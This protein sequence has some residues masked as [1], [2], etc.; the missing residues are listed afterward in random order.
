MD[1]DPVALAL[2]PVQVRWYG[3]TYLL[4]FAGFWLLGLRHAR[5]PH[6]AVAPAQVGEYS[7]IPVVDAA[8]VGFVSGAGPHQ[9]HRLLQLG[10]RSQGQ[11]SILIRPASS[12][13][14]LSHWPTWRPSIA[15]GCTGMKSVSGVDDTS[16]PPG[17]CASPLGNPWGAWASRKR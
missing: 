13:V 11:Q 1:W 3:L 15:E 9:A 8:E 16:I 17:C 14:S 10:Q 12:T 6:T 2:G 7:L 5:L 4:G